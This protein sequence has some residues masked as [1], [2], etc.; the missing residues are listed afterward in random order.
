MTGAPTC[1][2]APALLVLTQIFAR[3]R[4]LL[5]RRGLEPYRGKWAPPGG[6]VEDGESLAAAAVREVWEEVRIDL[7]PSQLLH[8]AVVSVPKINQVYHVFTARLDDILPAAAVAPESLEV[9]WFSERDLATIEIWDPGLF[10]TQVQK[11]L[12]AHSR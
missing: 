5:L 7:E 2:G 9:G 1:P 11:D 10:F 12:H 4:I 3:D 8:C 6:F